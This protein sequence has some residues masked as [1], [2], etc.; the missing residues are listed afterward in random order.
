MSIALRGKVVVTD[1]LY[2]A[3]VSGKIGAAGLDVTKPEPLPDGHPLFSLKNCGRL[4]CQ[5]VA[6]L[7]LE[8][9]TSSYSDR[10]T[11]RLCIDWSSSA[12]GGAGTGKRDRLPL[13]P[14]DAFA[15]DLSLYKQMVWSYIQGGPKK[16]GHAY[17]P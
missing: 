13:W 6:K 14:R 10:P 7:T 3:L 1:D 9:K 5:S 15:A 8:S 2:E 12:D 17:I 16:V 4:N 11:R